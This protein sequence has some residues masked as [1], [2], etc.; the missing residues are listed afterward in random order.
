M[1]TKKILITGI[2]GFIGSHIAEELLRKKFEIIGLKRKNSDCWRCE[3]IIDKIMWIDVDDFFVKKI[4]ALKPDIIVHCAWN[5]AGAED[6]N[7]PEVQKENLD[8][9]NAILEIAGKLKIDKLI[10]LGSQAEYGFLN[11]A[12]SENNL[13]APDTEYGKTKVAASK[14]I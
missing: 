7:N 2:T 8:F 3:D 9:L 12:V 11:K 1:N 4:V 5:G 13:I 10:G 6:R 14:N